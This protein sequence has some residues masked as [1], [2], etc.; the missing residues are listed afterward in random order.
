MNAAGC[1]NLH[2]E[3]HLA[4]AR[5]AIRPHLRLHRCAAQASLALVAIFVLVLAGGCSSAGGPDLNNAE[6]FEGFP[7]YWLGDTFEGHD[8]ETISGLGD[9]GSPVVLIYGTCT[10]SGGLE[11]TCALPLQLQI[12]PLCAQLDSVARAQNWRTRRI[13]GAPVGTIDGA[14]VLFTSRTQ[15]KVYRG[16]GTDSGSALRALAALRSLNDVSPVVSASDPIPPPAPGVLG[17]TR[18]CTD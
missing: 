16:E 4:A 9:Q 10:L 11:P 7:L 12:S 2:G 15:I 5:A 17:G 1:A 6:K 18:A 14:P 3:A 13:R 8:I